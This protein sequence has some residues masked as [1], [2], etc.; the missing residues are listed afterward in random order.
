MEFQWA[1]VSGALAGGIVGGFAGFV[2]NMIMLRFQSTQIRRSVARALSGE[3][4]AISKRIELEYLK[5]LSIELNIMKTEQ[6]YTS[7][8][9]R[10]QKDLT[11]VFC[12]LG[13][14]IGFLPSELVSELVSWYISLT[15]Y[16]E[17]ESEF[18]EL[19]TNKGLE[20]MEYAIELLELQHAGYADLV[21]KAR[22][23]LAQLGAI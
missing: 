2:S 18:H 22:P 1:Q 5:K 19:T 10:G 4:G 17:R 6:R 11:K 12:S 3:I 21:Q 8:H 14:H 9:F 20:V 7:H 13:G 16:Q 15:I 23:L